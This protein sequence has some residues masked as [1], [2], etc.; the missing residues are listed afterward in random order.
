MS[1]QMHHKQESLVFI[2]VLN[3]AG[4]PHNCNEKTIQWFREH[5]QKKM[6]KRQNVGATSYLPQFSL[7]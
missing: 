2:R 7:N 6:K 4:L 1:V 5:M 3:G